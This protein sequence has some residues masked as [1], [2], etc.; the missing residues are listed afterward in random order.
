VPGR[1][2]SSK[3]EVDVPDTLEAPPRV[4]APKVAK[5][6]LKLEDL[7]TYRELAADFKDIVIEF[8]RT[9]ATNP[10]MGFVLAAVSA[11][12]LRKVGVIDNGTALLID[13]TATGAFAVDMAGTVIDDL[14]NFIPS[15]GGSKTPPPD[16]V[17]PS[18]QTVVYGDSGRTKESGITEA[19]A[20]RL[21]AT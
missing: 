15:F 3:P 7:K 10:L 13:V 11:D 16:V 21:S 6:L 20:K 2:A 4:Q 1:E 9:A 19:L 18:V 17:T 5:V 12:I 14:G 8:I